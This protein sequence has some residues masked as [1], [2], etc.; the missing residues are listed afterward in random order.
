MYQDP[1]PIP[2]PIKVQQARRHL[3]PAC[4]A[5]QRRR[6]ASFTAA[7]ACHF[8]HV[9]RSSSR[10]RRSRAARAFA[11]WS[12]AGSAAPG[13]ETRYGRKELHVGSDVS[14]RFK[15]KPGGRRGPIRGRPS[16]TRAV[17]ASRCRPR[18]V[19]RDVSIGE[20]ITV[21]ELAQKKMHRYHEHGHH[22]II[23]RRQYRNEL[24]A[25]IPR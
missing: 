19:V 14:S 3:R 22:G 13:G 20:T 7:I 8:S 17:M 21:A 12:R 9:R 4:S 15:K 6:A 24:V 11:A 10:V 23:N 25:T 1:Q 16:V 5:Q 18:P 2:R